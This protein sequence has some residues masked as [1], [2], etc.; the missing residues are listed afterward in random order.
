MFIWE[1]GQVY[2]KW[3]HWCENSQSYKTLSDKSSEYL[4]NT[5][6]NIHT[7]TSTCLYRTSVSKYVSLFPLPLKTV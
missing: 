2:K 3:V 7:C 4:V 5:K 6:L 1:I